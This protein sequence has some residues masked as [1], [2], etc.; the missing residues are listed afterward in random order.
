MDYIKWAQEYLDEA[1]KLLRAISYKKQLLKTA[2]PDVCQCINSDIVK[3]RTMYYE[4]KLTAK[5]LTD[6]AEVYKLAA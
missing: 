4:C 1:D 3:L 6:R 2:T 5:H